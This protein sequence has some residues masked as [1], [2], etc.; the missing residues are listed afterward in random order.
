[1]GNAPSFIPL[2]F[3]PP[4]S[5]WTADDVPDMTGK[6]V[7]VTGTVTH[8][9]SML[10]DEM[11]TGGFALSGGNTGVGKETAKVSRF[12][13]VCCSAGKSD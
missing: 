3:P 7:I 2:L 12:P 9:F 1:M 11:L 13:H 6:V 10:L 5:Q 4:K 8:L